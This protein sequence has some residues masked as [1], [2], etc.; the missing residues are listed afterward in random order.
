M[1]KLLFLI[2]ES[3]N[4]NKQKNTKGS[5]QY[6]EIKHAPNKHSRLPKTKMEGNK[7]TNFKH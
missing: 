3:M 6:E 1:C 7:C 2:K 5:K 4:T